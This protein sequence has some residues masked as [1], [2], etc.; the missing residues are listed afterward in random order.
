MKN[1]LTEILDGL[2]NEELNE[3]FLNIKE[4]HEKAQLGMDNV[5]RRTHARIE[6]EL[7]ISY[8]MHALEMEILFR[9]A[10]RSHP[11]PSTE[12]KLVVKEEVHS[13]H[14]GEVISIKVENEFGDVSASIRSDGI[15]HLFRSF[16]GYDVENAKGDDVE[17]KM[18]LHHELDKNIAVLQQLR[19]VVHEQFPN[20]GKP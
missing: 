16:N 9:F 15:I 20:W 1:K 18:I 6:S 7:G 13:N 3:A 11:L 12:E 4:L 8:S 14:N 5:F 2:T 19:T 10:Q 17:Y